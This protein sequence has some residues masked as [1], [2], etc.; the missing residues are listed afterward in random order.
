M[1]C[2]RNEEWA[3]LEKGGIGCVGMNWSGAECTESAERIFL[4]L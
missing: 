2:W 3:E 1:Y 4:K